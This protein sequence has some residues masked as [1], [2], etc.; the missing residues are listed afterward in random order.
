MPCPW[1][2]PIPY[3]AGWRQTEPF[4]VPMYLFPWTIKRHQT[5]EQITIT[6]AS[7]GNLSP[8]SIARQGCRYRCRLLEKL[9]WESRLRPS[10]LLIKSLHPGAFSSLF[11]L[12]QRAER[13]WDPNKQ[14]SRYVI[15]GLFS[16]FNLP[17]S[18]IFPLDHI[19][20]WRNIVLK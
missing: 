3:R 20:L 7:A 16:P 1:T 10:C 2:W 14:P 5:A 15:S 9:A 12:S 4:Q 8:F 18:I 11:F 17:S 19:V 6:P 13:S